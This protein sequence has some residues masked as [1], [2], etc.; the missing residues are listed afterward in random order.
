MNKKVDI[1]ILVTQEI[2]DLDDKI[3]KILKYYDILKVDNTSNDSNV[4]L[5]EEN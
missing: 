2:K 3:N 5:K 4:K 1:K